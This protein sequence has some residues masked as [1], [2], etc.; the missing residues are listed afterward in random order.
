MFIIDILKESVSLFLEMAPYL[1]LGLVFVAL[2]N[3]FFTKELIARHVGKDNY[4][5]IIKASLLGVPLPLCSCGVIPSTVYMAKN[6][7]SKGATISFLISTPQ[8]GI[9]SI[10]ATY[11]MMGWVFAIYR[12]IIALIMGILGGSV[13]K[14]VNSKDKIDNLKPIPV[15]ELK[16]KK[17][18]NSAGNKLT[19]KIKST[20]RYAFIEFMD[21]IATQFIVGVI[22]AGLI[23]YLIPDNF[24]SSAG[25]SDGILGMLLMMTI[26][27]PMYVCATASIPIAVTLMMKGLSPGVAFVFLVTG[28]ATNAASLAIII[29][30]LGKKVAV[31]YLAVIGI[32]SI[33]FGYLLNF[34]FAVLKIDSAAYINSL[35][36]NHE[37]GDTG[38]YW[39][40]LTTGII[41]LIL[42]LIALYRKYLMNKFGRKTMSIPESTKVQIE[43]M[44][45][46]H[47]VMNVKKAI[48]SV[49]G[50][51]EVDVSLSDNA[52]F[53]KGEFKMNELKTA[54]EEVGYR[55]A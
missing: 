49:N 3:F 46:N 16:L 35:H 21:D 6:G 47:C 53:V 31:T 5:S 7:A 23:A 14:L 33:A 29:N 17:E 10:I 34:F 2:L 27:I 55:I 54:V 9:D 28:P 45:C 8:T 44:T 39:L 26:G 15:D 38:G 19:Q 25:I 52:A 30:T 32:S 51:T 11:G 42:L 13:I 12:P 43:G 18:E 41:L 48:T 40:K 22:I 24:F 36:M 4:W 1:M 50:V 20:L 37:H